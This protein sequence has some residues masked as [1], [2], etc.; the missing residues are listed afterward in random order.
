MNDCVRT[1]PL[2]AT[3]RLWV[4]WSVTAKPLPNLSRPQ[5]RHCTK[6]DQSAWCC[7][8]RHLHRRS[9]P[10]N[11]GIP[12][13]TWSGRPRCRRVWA[14]RHREATSTSTRRKR[15]GRSCASH[16]HL[17][18]W[19]AAEC[20]FHFDGGNVRM[21]TLNRLNLFVGKAFGIHIRYQEWNA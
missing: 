19:Y 14:G 10:N 20:T 3:D 13:R 1:S 5:E 6:R 8:Q 2:L 15:S 11:G 18:R 21:L 12:P 7:R 16:K 4:C 9:R 17:S